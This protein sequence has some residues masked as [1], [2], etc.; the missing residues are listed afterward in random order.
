[1]GFLS[2]FIAPATLITGLLFYFGYVSSRNFFLYFGVDVDVLGLSNQQF[3]MRSPGA[4]FVPI[5]V[6]L[7]IAA[8]LIVAHRLLR[9]RL[10]SRDTAHQARTVRVI[11]W[12]GIALLIAGLLLAFSYAL[13]AG[14]ELYGFVTATTLAVGAGLAAYAAS[15]ARMLSGGTQGRSVIVLLIAVMVA[16]TFWSTSSVAEWW[17]RGQA[18]ILAAE[19][20]VLPAVVVDT[21]ERLFPGSEAIRGVD[22][23]PEV[24]PSEA[25]AEGEESTEA[26]DGAKPAD[27][28]LTYRYRYYGMRLLVRGGDYLFLVPDTWSPE[29]STYVMKI[30][31]S[32]W[33]FRFFP[34]EDPPG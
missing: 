3:V 23:E 17:G 28:P 26:T 33:R 29:A 13:L 2:R 15:T 18:Q 7:L 21:T 9:R 24:V 10:K 22:L 8:A 25:A 16:G 30:D 12:I 34:D 32:R 5:M 4:L 20:T 14:W 11:A 1:M 6:L 19:L 31:D 27:A